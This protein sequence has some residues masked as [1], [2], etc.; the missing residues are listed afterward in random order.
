M[1]HEIRDTDLK[2]ILEA[3]RE[4]EHPRRRWI[5]AQLESSDLIE[6]IKAYAPPP[7]FRAYVTLLSHY[8]R[9]QLFLNEWVGHIKFEDA[10]GGCSPFEEVKASIR[11]NT[12][13][14][15]Y[16]IRIPLAMV[17][18]WRQGRYEDIGDDLCHEMCHVLV[19]PLVRWAKADA[20]PSQ[21]SLI[22]DVDE[23]QTQRIARVIAAALPDGWWKPEYLR[24]W[25]NRPPRATAPSPRPAEQIPL[26]DDVRP[27]EKEE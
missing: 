12:V 1:T 18:A 5:A 3:L 2:E 6:R 14:L 15:Y 19:E 23:Q 10:G 22:D 4:G 13:Y 21:T 8:L 27:A 9:C 25:E 16:T 7:E 20:A 17:E 26:A 11:I 24:E